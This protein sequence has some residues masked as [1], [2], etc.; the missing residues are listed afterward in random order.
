MYQD[1]CGNGL[2][3]GLIE[4][5]GRGDLCRLERRGEGETGESDAGDEIV[6]LEPLA[7]VSMD[8]CAGYGTTR[9]VARAKVIRLSKEQIRTRKPN[10]SRIE[11]RILYLISRLPLLGRPVSAR[12]SA[13]RDWRK[14]WLPPTRLHRSPST[15][16]PPC[17]SQNS[18]HHNVLSAA[19]PLGSCVSQCGGHVNVS[20]CCR[21]VSNRL[22]SQVLVA[23]C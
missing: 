12:P 2:A 7:G 8:R 3:L 4:H 18:G 11:T 17:T 15:M 20:D 22:G 9:T 6:I 14:V 23:R 13:G 16:S 21:Q 19:T 1:P 10:C 5:Q